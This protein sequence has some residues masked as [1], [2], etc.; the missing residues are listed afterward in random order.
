MSV[1]VVVFTVVVVV[2]VV[3]VAVAVVAVVVVAVVPVLAVF[4]VIVFVVDD[5]VIKKYPET[6]HTKD[7]TMAVS[8]VYCPCAS[9][10]INHLEIFIR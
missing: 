7:K 8:E 3:F 5:V 6:N 2:V 1:I 9:I 10:H 4:V